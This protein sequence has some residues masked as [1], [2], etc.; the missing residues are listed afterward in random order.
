MGD[1]Q[2]I[3]PR[4]VGGTLAVR[5]GTESQAAQTLHLQR[6]E[7]EPQQSHLAGVTQMA[8]KFSGPPRCPPLRSRGRARGC[9]EAWAS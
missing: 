4:L 5:L 6:P 3:G 8:T 2:G 9:H 7:S 1:S